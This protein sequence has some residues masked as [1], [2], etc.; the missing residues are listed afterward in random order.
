MFDWEE[1]VVIWIAF[2]GVWSLALIA[3][4]MIVGY[5]AGKV[6]LT[7]SNPIEKENYLQNKRNIRSGK[8]P[9]RKFA[10][11]VFILIFGFI[12]TASFLI[13]AYKIFT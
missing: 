4:F 1:I 5:I 2:G 8:T 13:I 10:E 9:L 6:I 12:A 3:L 11:A 7:P